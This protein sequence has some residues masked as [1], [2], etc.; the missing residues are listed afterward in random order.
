MFLI[1][2]IFFVEAAELPIPETY[3]ETPPP[4]QPYTLPMADSV[5][6]ST[7]ADFTPRSPTTPTIQR[8]ADFVDGRTHPPPQMLKLDDK[9]HRTRTPSFTPAELAC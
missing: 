3:W 5:T 7:T 4:S 8:L 1:A 9:K 6:G 2:T